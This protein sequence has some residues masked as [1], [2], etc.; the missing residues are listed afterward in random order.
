MLDYLNQKTGKHYRSNAKVNRDLIKARWSDG[1]RFD[2]FKK[3]V[4]NMV[5]EWKGTG[6]TFSSGELAEKYLRPETL[7]SGK[8][9]RYLNETVNN[10]ANNVPDEYQGLFDQQPEYNVETDD[11]PF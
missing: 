5:A 4:D 2:D 7:F 3:V 10:A 8:F 9:D 6:I 1:Y 11:L